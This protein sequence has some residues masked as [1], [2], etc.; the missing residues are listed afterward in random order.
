MI[1]M[2]VIH[3]FKTTQCFKCGHCGTCAKNQ[4]CTCPVCHGTELGIGYNQAMFEDSDR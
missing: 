4:M 3:P 1:P 2:F